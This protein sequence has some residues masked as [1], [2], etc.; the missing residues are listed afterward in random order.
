LQ[1]K[2]VEK[3][4]QPSRAHVSLSKR[5]GKLFSRPAREVS[6]LQQQQQQYQPASADVIAEMRAAELQ[7]QDEWRAMAA[8][9]AAAETQLEQAKARQDFATANEVK[10]TMALLEK[11][12]QEQYKAWE[13]AERGS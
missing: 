6:Q 11:A 1:A 7:Q 9:N 2:I 3:Q 5:F 13:G 8:K 12:Q 10:E 4:Q